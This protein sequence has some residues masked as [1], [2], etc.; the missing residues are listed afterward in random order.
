MV[1]LFLIGVLAFADGSAV[2]QDDDDEEDSCIEWG[3]ECTLCLDDE[4]EECDGKG[5]VRISC[6][7][8][9]DDDDE[10]SGVCPPE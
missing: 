3:D 4:C 9:D 8:D 1:G 6:D 7:D 5:C 10:G 2:A